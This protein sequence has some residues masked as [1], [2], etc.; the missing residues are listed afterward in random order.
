[1]PIANL[2]LKL[3]KDGLSELAVLHV[4]AQ[5]VVLGNVVF[6]KGRLIVRDQGLLEGMKPAQFAPCYESGLLGMVGPPLGF[7]WQS[8]TFFGLEECAL[9]VDL[10]K[11][12]HAALV[13]AQNQ[14][15]ESLINFTGSVYRGYQLMLDNHFLPVVIMKEVHTKKGAG[16]LAISDLRTVPMDLSVIRRINDI[17]RASV[18]RRLVLE[19]ENVR[20]DD[21]EFSKLFANYL[22]GVT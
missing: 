3:F 20:M 15:G 11:T 9:P 16:G 2:V 1:M 5:S 12:R 10:S 7:A 4:T 6:E 19:V 22:H 13:A 8:L 18:E 14:Y 21:E 17:V